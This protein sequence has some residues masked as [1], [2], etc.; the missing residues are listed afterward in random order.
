MRWNPGYPWKVERGI[1][2]KREEGNA[3]R[4]NRDDCGRGRVEAKKGRGC[5]RKGHAEV[6][7]RNTYTFPGLAA[8]PPHTSPSSSSRQGQVT[9]EARIDDLNGDVLVCETNHW[10][11]AILGRSLQFRS[12]Y[13]RS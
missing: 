5:Y 2:T 13:L 12:S 6:A 1:R 11:E 4:R 8:S 10:N 7:E 3:G 9:L